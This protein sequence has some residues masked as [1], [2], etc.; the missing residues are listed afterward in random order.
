MK[1]SITIT[2]K[3]SVRDP[4][5]RAIADALARL[6]FDQIAEVRQGKHIEIELGGQD[7]KTA[8]AEIE[9][10][11]RKFLINPVI[12]DYKIEIFPSQEGAH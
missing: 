11:C 10:M 4:Q 7:L 5:G 6:G 3:K 9:N 8:R 12:E 2:L 1:A